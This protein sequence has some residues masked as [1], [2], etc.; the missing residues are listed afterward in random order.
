MRIWSAEILTRFD[1]ID[2]T[3]KLGPE[4]RRPFG[5]LQTFSF[6]DDDDLMDTVSIL[7]AAILENYLVSISIDGSRSRASKWPKTSEAT[8]N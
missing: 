7:E 1:S 2:L 5:K 8:V 6:R 3:K 4:L